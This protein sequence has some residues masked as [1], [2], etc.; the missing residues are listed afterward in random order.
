M[1]YMEPDNSPCRSYWLDKL[2]EEAVL[3]GDFWMKGSIIRDGS[4]LIGTYSFAD[5]LNGNALYRL[6]SA[7]FS[8]FL[9]K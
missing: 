5:H 4:P 9:T 8:Q 3:H 7:A 6:D 2:Y 1:Y